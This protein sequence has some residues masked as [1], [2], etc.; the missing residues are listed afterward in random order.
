MKRISIPPQ[1][2]CIHS[3]TLNT[4][5]SHVKLNVGLFETMHRSHLKHITETTVLKTR[6]IQTSLLISWTV[7]NKWYHVN[8][9]VSKDLGCWDLLHTYLMG[10]GQSFRLWL[11][12][13]N[14]CH[15]FHLKCNLLHY[16]TCHTFHL[17]CNLKKEATDWKLVLLQV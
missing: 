10:D 6:P 9:F 5:Q 7:K 11:Y 13:Y 14:T 1:T 16:N 2:C 3:P 8:Y 17:K 12:N 15:T 4:S